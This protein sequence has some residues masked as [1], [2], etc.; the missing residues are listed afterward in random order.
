VGDGRCEC[1]WV[2]IEQSLAECAFANA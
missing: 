2:C 1:H